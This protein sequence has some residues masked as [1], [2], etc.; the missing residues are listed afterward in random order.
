M[1]DLNDINRALSFGQQAASPAPNDAAPQRGS[2][3]GPGDKSKKSAGKK[4][5][6][7]PKGD[8]KDPLNVGTRRGSRRESMKAKEAKKIREAANNNKGRR[9]SLFKKSDARYK[10]IKRQMQKK[11]R[12]QK[13]KAESGEKQRQEL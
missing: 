5:S 6:E 1:A 3:H 12:D 8:P 2:I 7:S 13:K 10:E 11:Q 9:D 4:G